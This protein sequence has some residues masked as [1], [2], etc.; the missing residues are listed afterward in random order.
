MMCG[1]PP[2]EGG[3]REREREGDRLLMGDLQVAER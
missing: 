2:R 1:L 3:E